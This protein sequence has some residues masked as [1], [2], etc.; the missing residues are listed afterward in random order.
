MRK[1]ILITI[2][3]AAASAAGCTQ[4]DIKAN[5]DKAKAIL[6]AVNNGARVAASVVREGID[7]VCANSP[8][9]ASGAIAVRTGLQTQTGPNTTQNLDNLDKSSRGIGRRLQPGCGQS[10]RSRHQGAAAHR[11]VGLPVGQDIAEQSHRG[12]RLT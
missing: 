3:A 7:S 9:I 6:G 4:S 1:I 10:K 2:L 8:A 12:G 5:E 11:V